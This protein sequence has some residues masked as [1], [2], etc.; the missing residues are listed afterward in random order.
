MRIAFLMMLL[1]GS[2]KLLAQQTYTA[3]FVATLGTDTVIV[4]TYNMLPNHLYGKAFLRYPEDQVGV[5]DFHFYPDGS[6]RHYSMSFMN[7]DSSYITSNGTQGVYCEND[8][9]SPPKNPTA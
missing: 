2:W 4:E 9:V 3:S 7:P 6:I 1:C 8:P 5:F